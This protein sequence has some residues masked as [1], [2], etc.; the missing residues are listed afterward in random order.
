MCGK[1]DTM[2][3]HL[4]RC[5]SVKEIDKK[6]AE[7]QK[8]ARNS[9]K[10]GN[11]GTAHQPL[12]TE[13]SSSSK[14]TPLEDPPAK[15]CK[16]EATQQ[17]LNVVTTKRWT[18]AQQHDFQHDLCDLFVAC[19]ISWNSVSNPQLFLFS[20]KWIPGAEIPDRRVL[21]RPI[22]KERVA[23][24][25]SEIKKKVKGKM[26]MGQCDRWKNITKTPLVA[27]MITVEYQVS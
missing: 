8:K 23:D 6:D 1:I 21:A 16:T 18:A 17:N 20:K 7:E 5:D 13:V 25:E 11:G 2:L 4:I 19:G 10:R 24:V 12:P 15:C 14:S 27:L 26:A 9:M 3:N 22:L